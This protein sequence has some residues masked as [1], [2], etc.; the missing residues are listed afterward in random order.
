MRQQ[1]AEEAAS[2]EKENA[3]LTV[4]V[5]LLRADHLL[6]GR[7]ANGLGQTLSGQAV[8]GGQQPVVYGL[9]LH[10]ARHDVAPVSWYPVHRCWLTRTPTHTRHPSVK[11]THNRAGSVS[12]LTRRRQQQ[13]H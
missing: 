6:G 2:K 3:K 11:L 9:A 12:W 1:K 4:Q 7:L 13:Q 10:P 8:P 5:F